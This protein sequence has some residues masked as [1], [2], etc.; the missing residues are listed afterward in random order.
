MTFQVWFCCGKKW[1]QSWIMT[2]C[3]WYSNTQC[4]FEKD[5]AKLAEGRTCEGSWMSHNRGKLSTSTTAVIILEQYFSCSRLLFQ[6]LGN[7]SDHQSSGLLKLL[8]TSLSP[9][10]LV[11]RTTDTTYESVAH[12][13]LDR[14]RGY[15]VR[16]CECSNKR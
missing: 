6:K 3:S 14:R 5:R 11:L 9:N 12:S 4:S 10:V 2:R 7:P 13:R 16:P 15:R 8:V 1:V